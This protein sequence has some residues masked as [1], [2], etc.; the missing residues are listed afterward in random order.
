MLC[1]TMFSLVQT[2]ALK[3]THIHVYLHTEV[4]PL[5]MPQQ[6]SPDGV[7]ARVFSLC[8]FSCLLPGL[9]PCPQSVFLAN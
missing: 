2:S 9:A 6:P 7:T 1:V 3:Y 5:F 4:Q 8:A